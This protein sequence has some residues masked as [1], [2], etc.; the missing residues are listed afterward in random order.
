MHSPRFRLRTLMIAVA[1]AGVGIGLP[2]GIARRASQFERLAAHH[3]RLEVEH[4]STLL[5]LGGPP[6]PD[7]PLLQTGP[8]RYLHRASALRA[9]HG[10]LRRKYADAARHPW[11]S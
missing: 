11:L 10:E 4:L 2:L 1:V 3:S 6:A 9:Y 7:S 5:M 8:G